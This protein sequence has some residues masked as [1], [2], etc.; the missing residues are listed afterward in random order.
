MGVH[1]NTHDSVV[2]LRLG[3]IPRSST[4][5]PVLA[6]IHCLAFRCNCMRGVLCAHERRSCFTVSSK[7][8]G[9]AIFQSSLISYSGRD[10][11]SNWCLL[12]W[13]VSISRF[14]QTTFLNSDRIKSSFMKLTVKD[15]HH[16]IRFHSTSCMVLM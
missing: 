4:P 10:T 15:S 11:L 14:S 9:P 16:S 12:H 3:L 8:T 2:I 7:V 5:L 6:I 13:W 1:R